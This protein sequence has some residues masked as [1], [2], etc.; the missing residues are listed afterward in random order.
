MKLTLEQATFRSV[1]AYDSGSLAE[2]EKICRAIISV[3]PD[4]PGANFLLG[5]IALDVKKPTEALEFFR[6]VLKSN[7]S[8]RVVGLSYVATLVLSKAI[9]MIEKELEEPTKLGFDESD[10][11]KLKAFAKSQDVSPA[12]LS[13]LLKEMQLSSANIYSG[14]V[15]EAIQKK[16]PGKPPSKQLIIELQT[17]FNAR[18]YAGAHRLA[19]EIVKKHP[20]FQFAWKILG[21][22]LAQLG[23]PAAAEEP[24]RKSVL[25]DPKDAQAHTNLSN[26]LLELGRLHEAE[27]CCRTAIRLNPKLALAHNNLGNVLSALNRFP[28]AE[29]C[30][31][32][33]I[34][35]DR[36][37]AEAYCNL[38]NALTK[39]GRLDEAESCCREAIR[40]NPHL[41]QA[42]N[43]L[44][45]IFNNRE[46]WSKAI[47]SYRTATQLMP[48]FVDAHNNLGNTFLSM[49]LLNDAE[50][51]YKKVLELYPN[52]A[53][54]NSGIGEVYRQTCRLAEAEIHCK[55][56]VHY[57]R[58]FPE[59]YINLGNIYF[60]GNRHDE[61]EQCYRQA[62]HL[63]PNHAVGHFNLANV[64][65]QKGDLGAAEAAYQ[66]AVDLNPN[67]LAA[68]ANFGNLLRENR[69]FLEA[70]GFYRKV[71]SLRPDL[72]E[73]HNNLGNVLF[74]LGRHEIA[75]ASYQ[76]ALRLN[77]DYAEAMSNLGNV[78]KDL[79]RLDEA[80]AMCRNA[81]RIKP[82]FAEAFC[83]LGVILKERG[84]LNDAEAMYRKALS[85]NPQYAMACNNL[86]SVLKHLGR[87]HEAEEIQKKAIQLAPNMPEYHSN[88]LLL[89]LYINKTQEE[90]WLA[91]K[92]FAIQFEKDFK[93]KQKKFSNVKEINRRLRIG[94]VSGD[95]R[96]HAVAFFIKPIL[97][98]HNKSQ[99]ETF[100][101]SNNPKKDSITFD[102]ERAVD[103]WQSCFHL[104]DSQL[105]ELIKNDGID[106][107]ID[108]SGHT[109]YNRLLTFARKPAPIQVTWIG[110][111]GSTGLSA[112]DYRLT[113]DSLDPI[114]MSEPYH[115]EKLYRLPNSALPFEMIHGAP[116]VCSLP[117]LESGIF[118]LACLNGLQKINA[119]VISLWVEILEEIPNSR[120][121]LGNASDNQI[122]R[123]FREEI[124]ARGIEQNRLVFVTRMPFDQYINLYH[125]I[126]LCVDPFPYNG[127][128]TSL[129]SIWMGV[130]VLTLAGRSTQSRVGAAVLERA[131]LSQFIAQSVEEYK[132]KAISWSMN[133]A[134]LNAIRLSMR[135]RLKSSK[136]D[137]KAITSLVEDAYLDMWKIYCS[138]DVDAPKV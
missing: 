92:N 1:E 119:E 30:F 78:L 125:S 132:K 46:Q 70:E 33:A 121:I 15:A 137:S 129:Q 20:D 100:V 52:D 79:N 40:L 10:I 115:S 112:I 123:F 50:E 53:T 84:Q 93:E 122:T 18:D 4:N 47:E 21:V 51:S 48:H 62:I 34:Q 7:I 68:Y 102:L 116:D 14:Q 37:F 87:L 58:R 126:D 105:Y 77:N 136:M 91:Q 65:K 88:Y 85:I 3:Q 128:T 72:P 9:G 55:K 107:L 44:G 133:L 96:N 56:A 131:G 41:A 11:K 24:M 8:G 6:E 60:Q 13:S 35:I 31:R 2:A 106:I 28:E 127:G 61:A 16:K 130:P 110:Y 104:N 69:R 135:P 29:S 75:I 117:A 94:Y 45:N 39:Q 63:E 124:A 81:I 76:E 90:I 120:F 101:Y 19:F 89:I 54:A 109:A 118:T 98:H 74:Q 43:N 36:Q 22:A 82:R 80:E 32:A 66:K 64:L 108:L 99:F 73:G 138:R 97:E 5:R 114:G 95:L 67:L 42:F 57:Q 103:K 17:A 26:V 134:N 59:G 83:N 49:N 111:P 27:A 113:Y 71:V 86:G 38:G 23:N 25:L 12:R